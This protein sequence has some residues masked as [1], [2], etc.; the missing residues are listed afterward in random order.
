[1]GQIC[2]KKKK[3]VKRVKKYMLKKLPFFSSVKINSFMRDSPKNIETQSWNN[4]WCDFII[5]LIRKDWKLTDKENENENREPVQSWLICITGCYHDRWTLNW[6]FNCNPLWDDFFLFK[7]R[8]LFFEL[9][10]CLNINSQKMEMCCCRKRVNPF[11]Q[12]MLLALW[13]I[14]RRWFMTAV[15]NL[16]FQ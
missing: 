16:S 8:N 12:I 10:H 4:L 13:K 7:F 15:L 6:L 2:K 3:C 5:G 14:G 11:A 9:F 1:M